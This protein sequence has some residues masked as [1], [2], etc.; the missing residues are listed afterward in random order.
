MLFIP[1]INMKL[2]H[3][4]IAIMECVK[5]GDDEKAKNR[6]KA[7]CLRVLKHIELRYPIEDAN[8]KRQLERLKQA[9]EEKIFNSGISTKI[10]NNETVH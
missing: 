5:L 8:G 4:C 6:I 2:F 1:L 7:I 3:E 10:E 9:I